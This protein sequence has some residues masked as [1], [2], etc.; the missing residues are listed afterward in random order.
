VLLASQNLGDFISRMDMIAKIMEF[1]NN[2]ICKLKEQQQAIANQKNALEKENNKLE[3]LKA[4][5]ERT[6]LNL[7]KDIRDQKELLTKATEKEN[8]LMT[9]NQFAYNAHIK[10]VSLSRGMPSYSQVLLLESTAYSGDGITACGTETRRD[11]KGYSTIAVDPR[12][13]P[14]GSRVYIEGYG[15]AIADDIGGAIKGNIID[16]Y[17]NSNSEATNWGR[18]SVKVY[19]LN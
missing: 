8:Q 15:Y 1:D 18:R 19:L 5:N 10:D 2:I 4:G 16:L 12:I 17:F 11:P 9:A 13:I 3:A 7:N 14:L 6:L